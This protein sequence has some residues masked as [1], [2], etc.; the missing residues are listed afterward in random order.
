MSKQ[1]DP[2][3]SG[4]LNS[5]LLHLAAERKSQQTIKVYGDGV[6]GFL[7]WCETHDRPPLLDRPTANAFVSSLL[8]DGAA[9]TTAKSRQLALRRFSA[10]LAEEGEIDSD[11]LDGLKPPKV[12]QK[13]VPALSDDQC[14]DLIKACQNPKNKKDFRARRDEAIVRFMIETGARAGEVVAMTLADV[15]LKTFEATIERGKGGKGRVVPFSAQTAAAV[16]RY[17]SLRKK[18]RLAHLPDLWLGDR[19]RTF[20]YPALY[21]ALVRRSEVAGIDGFS[22]H[23]LRHTAATRWLAAGG[24]EQGLMSV[25]GWTR[26]DMLDR[27]TKHSSE[28]RAVEEARKLNLGDL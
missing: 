27:Y 23:K 7:R 5:W 17:L 2:D 11:K 21:G 12:D 10:W 6:K 13:V 22:P 16:D 1:D 20:E 28:R 24:S 19:G 4:L 26:R 18:H 14:R 9:A 15:D 3:I 8:A 25:A